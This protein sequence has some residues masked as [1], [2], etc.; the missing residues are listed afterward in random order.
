MKYNKIK[1]KNE[2][3]FVSTTFSSLNNVNTGKTSS[4][5]FLAFTRNSDV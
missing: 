3:E 2:K 5:I 4:K 1:K